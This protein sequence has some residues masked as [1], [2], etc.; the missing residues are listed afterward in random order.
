MSVIIEQTEMQL[1]I[2]IKN[3]EDIEPTIY[4]YFVKGLKVQYNNGSS[5]GGAVYA[6]KLVDDLIK[7][8]EFYH[9]L[10]HSDSPTSETNDA[11]YCK[12]N[13]NTTSINRYYESKEEKHAIEN[14]CRR[15][16][17]PRYAP[18]TG[19]GASQCRSL[20]LRGRKAGGACLPCGRP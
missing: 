8:D 11:C 13:H 4:D 12:S 6:F 2:H 7:N 15:V 17:A 19:A 1:S 5:K 16:Y 9:F 3:E 14:N 20:H 18:Q 10:R